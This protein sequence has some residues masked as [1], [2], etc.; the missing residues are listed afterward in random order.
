MKKYTTHTTTR[1]RL[2]ATGT[3]TAGA[4]CLCG[5][6]LGRGELLCRRPPSI[7]SKARIGPSHRT[8]A[9][10]RALV[11]S[12]FARHLAARSRNPA[13]PRRRIRTIAEGGRRRAAAAGVLAWRLG[14]AVWSAIEEGG[15]SA[16]VRL[17]C[18]W[19]DCAGGRV[20]LAGI[21]R[22]NHP[23]PETPHDAPLNERGSPPPYHPPHDDHTGR[24]RNAGG[25]RCSPGDS[26]G[27][28]IA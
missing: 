25:R 8:H 22:S 11:G 5:W 15:K 26:L 12:A 16:L 7:R 27:A 28:G 10:I 18:P 20:L 13:A 3:M 14:R 4:V 9:S 1:R 2:Q 19:F 17:R 24:P 6:N 21:G 23:N